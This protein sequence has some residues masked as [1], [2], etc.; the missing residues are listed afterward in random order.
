LKGLQRVREGREYGD[1]QAPPKERSNTFHDSGIFESSVY[2]KGAFLPTAKDNDD[3]TF[4]LACLL[5]VWRASI[6]Y[7]C[8]NTLGGR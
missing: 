8:T 4:G 7:A 6:E 2:R 5:S 1:D 3:H